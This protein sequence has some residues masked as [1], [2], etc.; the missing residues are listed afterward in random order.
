MQV[1]S[2]LPGFLRRR[3][4]LVGMAAITTIL[5][6]TAVGCGGSTIGSASSDAGHEE[7]ATE[8]RTSRISRASKLRESN[9]SADSHSTSRE[10]ADHESASASS[11]AGHGEQ[12]HWSYE[13]A[14]GPS[15]WG[16]LADA[17]ITCKAGTT[18]S[19]INILGEINA[20]SA[21][22]DFH[23]QSTALSILNN[24][25]TIQVNYAPGSTITLDHVEY[26]LLQ[27][28]FHTPS[29]HQS[30]GQ[31]FPM[32]GH[33]V[34]K[35]AHGE[36]AVVGVFIEEGH[37]NQFFQ[38][39]VQHLPEHADD[40]N[41]VGSVHLNVMDM[42][43][44]NHTSYS[45]SGSLTTPPCSEGVSWNVMATPIQA[46]PA[47]LAAF[48]NIM[49]ANARP[50]QPV[51]ARAVSGQ[52]TNGVG[53]VAVSHG[54]GDA[55]EESSAHGAAHWEYT[56]ASGQNYWGEISA[57]FNAC[58]DGSAQSPID[59][60]DT[61]RTQLRDIEFHYA[62][63]DLELV[64]N[65]HTIQVNY[66]EGSYMLVDGNRFNLLQFH[67]HWP[68]EHTVDGKQFLMEAHLVHQ[69]AQGGLGVLGVLMERGDTNSAIDVLWD[70]MPPSAGA[71]REP[72]ITFNVNDLLPND[73]TTYRYPG[74]LTTPPCSE[75]VRWMLLKTPVRVSAEQ[76]QL[77]ED[78]VGY[79][80]R[81][82]NP[83][84][85]REVLEDQSKD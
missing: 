71:V 21:G 29:E 61:I 9:G 40:Q 65:G 53:V 55:E 1:S 16:D 66:D 36:L 43:P 83:L 79:N 57:D 3:R 35:N 38:S 63:T 37:S 48:S 68:S 59:V 10:S 28:H 27:F 47:E 6:I 85:G 52:T 54:G 75:G 58:V 30:S 24:G 81:Y 19:P 42:L 31:A 46:S 25:H 32:E 17:F 33:L 60:R 4:P 14:D 5:A 50:V 67:F 12:V 22:I 84:H 70:F 18:Q 62:N 2:F 34:H 72:G 78:T 64:N 56:G 7:G 41:D 44:E 80:S 73:R 15:H 45:Y 23:Y 51:N 77:F 76:A 49:G 8:S 20:A 74:S 26:D 13:G 11:A 39:L 82:T 69:D